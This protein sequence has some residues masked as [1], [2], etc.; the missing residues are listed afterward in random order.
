MAVT[1][2]QQ[3]FQAY[4]LTNLARALYAR[5]FILP[6]LTTTNTTKRNLRAP[7]VSF[8]INSTLVFASAA[9]QER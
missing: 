6:H 2:V 4:L 7:D 1:I 8:V 9:Y 3:G 5:T